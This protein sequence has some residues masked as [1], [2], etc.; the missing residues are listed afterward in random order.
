VL[1][2]AE[3]KQF[4]DTAVN[5]WLDDLKDAVYVAD[6]Q[7]ILAEQERHL[8]F[9]MFS[10]PVHENYDVFGRAKHLRMFLAIDFSPPPFNNENAAC[11]ILSNLKSLRV[12]LF[13]SFP[14]LVAL[15]DSIGELVHLRYLDLSYRH[16]KTLP[17]SLC[18]LYNLQTLKMRS[19]RVLTNEQSAQFASS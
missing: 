7:D 17:E 9:S 18:N 3:Q 13:Q 10:D 8:S 11:I 5:K 2:D 19:C 14:N 16:I 1:N 12:L 4:I 6:D 15:P